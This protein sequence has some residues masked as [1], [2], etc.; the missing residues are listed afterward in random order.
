MKKILV[1]EGNPKEKSLCKL[2]SETYVRGAKDSGHEVKI[3]HISDMKFDPNLK[4][5]Y[6]KNQKLEKDLVE[7]QK[8]ILW[9]N[10]L[11]FVYPIWWGSL[12]AKFKGLV[13]RVFLPGFAFKFEKRTIL[14]KQFLKGKS[15]RMITTRGGSRIFYF[16]SLSFPGMIM[17]RFLLNFCGVFPVRSKSFYSVN[18]IS[19]KRAKKIFDNIYRIGKRER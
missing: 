1:F 4:E 2:I 3:F 15:A 7:V 9:A 19:E 14:P 18:H 5:G 10:H 17:R 6:N 13:D 11:V 12:P 16:G 8:K